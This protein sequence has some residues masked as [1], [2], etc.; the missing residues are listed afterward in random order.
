MQAP[1][2]DNK[3][4][5]VFM[6]KLASSPAPSNFSTFE[7]AWIYGKMQVDEYHKNGGTAMRCIHTNA[8]ECLAAN[9]HG[10]GGNAFVRQ[11]VFADYENGS[12]ETKMALGEAVIIEF[13]W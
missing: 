11:W 9:P 4:Y 7:A 10:A 8:E 12:S 6:C 1:F 5:A 2:C 3:R 13:Q